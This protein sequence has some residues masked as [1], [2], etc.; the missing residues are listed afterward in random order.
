MQTIKQTYTINAPAQQVWEVLTKTKH[1]EQWT[2]SPAAFDSSEGGT[3]SL[4]GG[5]IHGVNTKVVPPTLLE[6]DWYSND[7]ANPNHCYKVSF[8]LS[9]KNGITTIELTHAGVPDSAVKDYAD[10]WHDY[11]FAP[12]KSLLEG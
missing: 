2:A 4:W 9:E 11:Y 5:D 12:I 8:A 10:G 6:E 7:D 1:I 3:F